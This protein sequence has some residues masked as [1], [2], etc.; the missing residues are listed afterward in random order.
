MERFQNVK[1]SINNAKNI[2]IIFPENP[3]NDTLGSVLALYSALNQLDKKVF[4]TEERLP[5]KAVYFLRN[6]KKRIAITLNEEVSE[7]YYEKK[8]NHVDLNIIPKNQDFN[9]DNFSWEII[10]EKKNN[11]QTEPFDIIIIIG[12]LRFKEIE[13][14][15]PTD[16]EELFA[17]TIVNIDKN[18]ANENYGDVNIIGN[19]SLSK[20]TAILIKELNEFSFSKEVFD[21]LFFGFFSQE[22]I[23]VKD[24]TVIKWILNNGGTLDI[25]YEYQ[26]KKKPLWADYFED[27][28]KNISL[29]EDEGIIFSYLTFEKNE[30]TEQRN[31]EKVKSA[32]QISKVFKEWLNPK[33]FFLSFKEENA[34]K[35]IFYSSSPLMIKKISNKYKGLFKETGGIIISNDK[36]LL[37]F[38]EELK[39]DL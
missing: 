35:T 25:Y 32:L 30:K 34:T 20:I 11:E 31:S 7:I 28:L 33:T 29:K 27:A 21:F 15:L 17:C 19:S 37:E 8:D 14:Y 22:K 2:K 5:E 1:A 38:I 26:K 9:S 6:E 3:D 39:K 10:S 36:N 13:K 24:I 12:V 4:L 16:E 23:L 18:S